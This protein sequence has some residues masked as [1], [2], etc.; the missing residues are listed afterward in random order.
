MN[1]DR[2]QLFHEH[3]LVKEPGTSKETPWHQDNPYYFITGNQTISFWTPM[4]YVSSA[5][6]RCVA[7]SH[8]WEKPVLPTKWLNETSFYEKTEGFRAVPDPGDAVAFHFI[9]LHGVLEG[10]KV[11]IDE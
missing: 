8:K 9:T 10:I 1:S 7:S 2:V 5:S 6:L 4:E 3:I 11:K